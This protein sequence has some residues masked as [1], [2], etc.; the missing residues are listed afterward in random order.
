MKDQVDPD[1]KTRRRDEIMSAQQEISAD[2]GRDKIGRIMDVIVEGTIPKDGVIV[3][4]TYADTP[5]VD[6]Y[7]FV[8]SP[9]EIMTGEIIKVLITGST[10][11]DLMGE[12]YYESAE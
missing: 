10:E 11:Y 12:V 9:V 6:G 4:R 5:D 1:T 3:G 2:H 7:V 8:E